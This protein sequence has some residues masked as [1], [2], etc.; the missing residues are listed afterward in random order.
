VGCERKNT[1]FCPYYGQEACRI[2][3]VGSG[4]G[5]ECVVYVD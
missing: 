5:I 1:K 3:D 2:E 4:D